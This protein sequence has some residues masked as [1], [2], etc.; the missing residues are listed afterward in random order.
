MGSRKE[1]FAASRRDMI[2]L[3][4]LCFVKHFGIIYLE[5]K[6]GIGYYYGFLK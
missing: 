5:A 3:I 2:R 4:K 1:N 6:L